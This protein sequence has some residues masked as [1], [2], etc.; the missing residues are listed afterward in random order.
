SIDS[1]KA[2]SEYRLSRPIGYWNALG[3]LA[4]M[5]IVLGVGFAARGR[6]RLTRLFSAASLVV[7]A[8]TLYFTYSRGAAIAAAIGL[9]AAIVFDTRRLQLITTIVI[10]TPAPAIAVVVASRLDGLTR[11]GSTLAQARHDGHRLALI[12]LLLA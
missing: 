11:K 12:L 8:P 2:V 4:G 5:G 3:V 9:V 7:L 6:R 1:A 10:V